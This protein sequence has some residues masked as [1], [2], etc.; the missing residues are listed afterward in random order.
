MAF[1]IPEYLNIIDENELLSVIQESQF[2]NPDLVKMEKLIHE[3]RSKYTL[4]GFNSKK[5]NSDPIVREIGTLFENIFGFYSFQFSVDHSQLPNAFTCPLSSKI[6]AWN[7]KKCVVKSNTGLRFTPV[8]KVNTMAV[9]TSG[10]LFNDKFTDR[11]IIAILLHEIGHNFSD[12]INNTLGIFSNF[13]KVLCI[14]NLFMRPQDTSNAL[15]KKATDFNNS[16]RKNHPE[17][18]SSFNALKLFMSK[19]EYVSLNVN[20]ALSVIP[21]FAISNLESIIKNVITQAIYNPASI[22]TKVVFNF[23]GK[24]DEYTSD[25]F[26]AMYGYG[27]DLASGLLKIER[28]N[29]TA[30][31]EMFKEGQFSSAYFSLMVETV[32][33]VN[34]LVT[35]SH[36][37]TAKRLLNVLDVL[38]KE[39]NQP[40]INPK[41][42]KETKK[43]IDEIRRLIDEEMENQS[44]DGNTWRIAWNK[45]IFANSSKS[46]KDKMVGDMLD[47]ISDMAEDSD[48]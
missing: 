44:F 45:H 3:L 27:P 41:F 34:V 4:D 10:L 8:A 32:D 9:I 39:Y 29:P 5:V 19:A 40:Y 37:P 24:E 33:M 12:S 28:H 35:N 26:V 43:E 13:K 1:Y 36:P 21:Q 6:D 31:D 17:M 7:Y 47:K 30:V 2:Y 11:E 15:R 18:V 42:K 23:F 16:M 38:E 14:P 46:P 25:S 20:R 22:I 48:I